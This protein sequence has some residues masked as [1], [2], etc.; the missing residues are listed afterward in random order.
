MAHPGTVHGVKWSGDGKHFLTICHDPSLIP[1]SG[2]LW[3][4]ATGKRIALPARQTR[5]NVAAFSPDHR[6][7]AT[8]ADDGEVRLWNVADGIP[9]TKS[10]GHPRT[11]WVLD[12]DPKGRQLASASMDQRVRLWDPLTGAP[13]SPALEHGAPVGGLSFS[14]AEDAILVHGGGRTTRWNLGTAS[15]TPEQLQIL[16]QL[17][18]ACRLDE[19]GSLEPLNSSELSVLLKRMSF[20]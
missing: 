15:G 18:S 10:F 12:F 3:D 11:C 9:A 19:T 4:T 7:V 17:T 1:R 5:F 6:F 13:L 16:A 14:P 8:G 2:R 20:R